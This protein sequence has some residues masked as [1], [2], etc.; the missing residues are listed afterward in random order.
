MQDVQFTKTQQALLSTL[1]DGRPHLR[2]ELLSLIPDDLSI[3][4]L[5]NHIKNIRMKLRPHGHDIVCEL[6]NRRI[7][8]RHV[9]LL[10][11]G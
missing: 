1:A 4:S 10:S 8:Y 7:S 2:S 5:N 11:R 9:I 3:H 6:L